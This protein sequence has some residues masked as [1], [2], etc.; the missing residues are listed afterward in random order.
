MAKTKKRAANIKENPKCSGSFLMCL[1]SSFSPGNETMALLGNGNYVVSK[2][3]PFAKSSIIRWL[4]CIFTGIRFVKILF[5]P[6]QRAIKET[7]LIGES[8]H[9][10]F[11]NGFEC[12]YSA[13]STER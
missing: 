4:L 11:N 5:V 10:A 8:R 12:D 7:L 3:F 2:G 9:I 1:I 6:Q 13:G